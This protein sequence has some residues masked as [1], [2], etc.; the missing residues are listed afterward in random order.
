MSEAISKAID[1]TQQMP[2]CPYC[3]AEMVATKYDG[4]YDGF[5]YWACDCETLPIKNKWRGGYA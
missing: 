5:D 3:K 2:V 1:E 4:Y